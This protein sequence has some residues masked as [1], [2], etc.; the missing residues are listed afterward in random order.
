MATPPRI[1]PSRNDQPRSSSR[2]LTSDTIDLLGIL[3]ASQALSSETTLDRLHA[4]VKETLSALTGA[5]NVRIVLCD[6]GSGDWYLPPISGVDATDVMSVDEAGRQLLL[7]LSAF[8]C[9]L[10]SGEILIT[11]DATRDDRF[12]QDSYFIGVDCCSLLLVPIRKQGV[13]K[14]MLL[15]EN[16]LSR[17]AFSAARLDAVSL[18]AGQLAVS[19]DNALMYASLEKNV[20][21]RTRQLVEANRQLENL[22][23]TDALTGLVNRRR[24]MDALDEEWKRAIR[25]GSG[26]AIAMIDV[27]HFKRYNDHYGHLGGD[28]CL[29]QVAAALKTNAR[30]DLDVAARFGGEEFA[31]IMPGADWN[32]ARSVAE[33][34]R[35]A[36][37]DL[38]LPH[39]QSDLGMVSASASRLPRKLPA[40][41]R[42]TLYA[43]PTARFMKPNETAA[44]ACARH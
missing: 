11:E 32:T 13:S 19:V 15:L 2:G 28:A 41:P 22:S 33:R 34:I 30:Q 21:E 16:R 25:T 4:R 42:R 23:N 40:G 14:A 26:I 29:R 35:R 24:L 7:P 20:A 9:V 12:A 18:I 37:I 44:I 36:I 38:G 17:G 6:Q 39:A 8:H 27:D 1:E 43:S 10:H 3:Q 31:V 5:T